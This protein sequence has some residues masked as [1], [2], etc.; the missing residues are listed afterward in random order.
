MP[1]RVRNPSNEV[2]ADGDV[3]ARVA[4]LRDAQAYAQSS[5]QSRFGYKRAAA[6]ILDL[7][8][9]LDTLVD[10]GGALSRIFGIGPSST[11]VILEV[12]R[13]GGSPTVALGGQGVLSDHGVRSIPRSCWSVTAP[14]GRRR[15]GL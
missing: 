6:T 13:T 7:D 10:A 14:I 3:N 2:A 11:R 4:A 12:L 5:R 1:R 8:A 15:R 9:P